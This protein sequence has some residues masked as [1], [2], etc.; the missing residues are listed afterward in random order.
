[1]K[2]VFQALLYWGKKLLL[3]ALSLWLLSA[4]VFWV[5]RLAP[6]DPLVS[7]Y[8]QR[9]ERLTPQERQ[10]ARERLGLEEPI[11]V[12]YLR[13]LEGAVR[14]DFGVSYKYK[15]DVREVIAGRL[16]N[17]LA[18]GGLS[19]G[20]LFLLAP[21]LGLVCAWREDSLGDRLLCRVGTAASCIPEFW[22]SL[23]VIF[24]FAVTLR[25]L[26]SGGA[27]S[28]GGGG[29]WDRAA[30]LVL[31]VGVT[32]AGHLWYYAYMLRNLFLE[33][34]RRD[35]VLLARA[36]GLSRG[37]VLVRHCL[38]NLLPGYLSLMAIAVPHILG[39][40]YVVEQVF[41]YPGLGALAYESARC[42][43]YNLLMLT[44]LLSGG[45]VML[46]SILAQSVGERLDPRLGE[47]GEEAG[48]HG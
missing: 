16:G 7:Y 24:L 25:W 20:L 37:Q 42:Q 33:E 10:Q 17:T 29:F 46:F 4:A 44:C 26:P 14:G 43:D 28:I 1:M 48:P 27:Y 3:F 2:R 39:G 31:P 40:S 32:V 41:A 23:M 47:P 18:L 34:V 9:A 19:F 5:S 22:L 36:K 8:G 11:P 21:V 30:H 38:R 6:G 45:G 35:Y 13:W 15:T 12:Q